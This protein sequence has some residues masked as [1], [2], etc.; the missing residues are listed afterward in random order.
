[1][2]PSAVYSNLICSKQVPRACYWGYDVT[3][4]WLVSLGYPLT[5]PWAPGLWVSH[6]IIIT[7]R[8]L[9]P[10]TQFRLQLSIKPSLWKSSSKCWTDQDS[11]NQ[12]QSVSHHPASVAPRD[13]GG[14]WDHGNVII[15]VYKRPSGLC[16]VTDRGQS[17]ADNKHWSRVTNPSW[18]LI[19]YN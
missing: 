11:D 7:P 5:P 2:S 12:T 18:H 1:M 8:L 4:V 6:R 13:G 14:S 10:S 16:D 9:M 19:N 15:I 17:H 3:N